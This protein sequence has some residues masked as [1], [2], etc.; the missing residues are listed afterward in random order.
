MSELAKM[1][2]VAAA[3]FD[4]KFPPPSMELPGD[5]Y[6]ALEEQRKVE[7]GAWWEAWQ[8]MAARQPAPA[9]PVKT[10]QERVGYPANALPAN[11]I[12][13][14]MKQEIAELRAALAA[15]A[16]PVRNEADERDN[17]IFDLQKALA[18]W[19]P[20]V[21]QFMSDEM[22]QRIAR[23]AYMLVID[24]NLPDD[25]KTAEELHW[26]LPATGR[27]QEGAE[28]VCGNCMEP[29]A[30]TN[31]SQPEKFTAQAG[32]DIRHGQRCVLNY[33][34]KLIEDRSQP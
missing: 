10:W 34:G 22:S 9:L 26:I 17:E 15:I 24:G 33:E 31:R 30:A 12:E 14:A 6:D 13:S 2:A 3:E 32:E 28:M 29:I 8:L 5:E 4:K 11:K 25:F 21:N 27:V 20:Q 16:A 1:R 19:L 7:W 18:F 23:D